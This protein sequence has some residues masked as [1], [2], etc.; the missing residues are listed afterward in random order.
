MRKAIFEVEPYAAAKEAQKGVFTHIHSYEVLEVLRI[1]H[2]EGLYIDLIECHLK[3]GVSINDLRSIG[4]MEILS[5]VRSDG[6][7]HTCLV[8]GHEPK[9]GR[10]TFKKNELD[11][12]YTPPSMISADRVVVSFIGTPKQVAKFAEIVKARIGRITNLT[13]KP[14]TYQKKDLLSALTKK[15]KEIMVAAYAYGYYDIPRRI[16]SERLSSKLK[17][18]RPTLLEHLRKAE[19]RLLAEAMAGHASKPIA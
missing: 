18:S 14:A 4:N 5:V 6:D 10:D 16:S 11:L 19:R 7:K 17:I 8:K 15:Q 9:S 3:D 2:V 12:I 1:D 13:V